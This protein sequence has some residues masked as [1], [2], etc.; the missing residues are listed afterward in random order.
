[1][2]SGCETMKGSM[3][4]MSS[5]SLS[6]KSSEGDL[7]QSA[8]VR[9]REDTGSSVTP[10]PTMT[11][12]STHVPMDRMASGYT[13]Y[14][15]HNTTAMNNGEVA[16]FNDNGYNNQY[17]RGTVA[18]GATLPSYSGGVISGFDS[19]VEIYSIDGAPMMANAGNMQGQQQ[20]TWSPDGYSSGYVTTGPSG[21]QIY[22]KH[23]S[24]RL[25]GGD[26]RKLNALA[27]QAKFAPVNR[28]TVAGHASKPTQ[29]GSNSVQSHILNLKQSMN[30]SFAV[31]KTL[32]QKG[33]PAEKIKTVSWGATKPTGN[34]TQDRRVDIIMGEQ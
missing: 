23:G 21:N 8:D 16:V 11:Q 29:A 1:M 17:T 15:G 34:N 33:V 4:D 3:R 24:A 27:D 25:G 28:I 7:N 19:S 6:K 26:M 14:S 18:T 30:R 20:R 32:M 31:S 22:F 5:W 13:G 2:L 12:Q 10:M 9:M